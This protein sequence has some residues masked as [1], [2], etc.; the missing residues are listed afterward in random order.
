MCI[1]DSCSGVSVPVAY[2]VVAMDR[3]L[4]ALDPY[5]VAVA[6]EDLLLGEAVLEAVA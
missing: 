2:A 6:V 3:T 5:T 4:L 1:R